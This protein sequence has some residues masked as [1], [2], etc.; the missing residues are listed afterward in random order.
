MAT[1]K[2]NSLST[3]SDSSPYFSHLEKS[4]DVEIQV[5]A[6][7]ISVGD[8]GLCVQVRTESRMPHEISEAPSQVFNHPFSMRFLQIVLLTHAGLSVSCS[9]TVL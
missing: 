6:Y 3:L 4:K 2:T 8:F 9:I 7:Y 1:K 5:W